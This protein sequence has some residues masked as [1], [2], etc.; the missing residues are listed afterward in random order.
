MADEHVRSSQAVASSIALRCESNYAAAINATLKNYSWLIEQSIARLQPRTT[1]VNPTADATADADDAG[2]AAI[3]GGLAIVLRGGAFRGSDEADGS[4]RVLAQIRCAQS[5]ERFLIRP[6]AR[7]G[8]RAHVFLTLY[9]VDV[10]SPARLEALQRP[11]AQHVRAITTLNAG[12]AEQLTSAIAA[13]DALTLYCS[14]RGESYEAVLLTRYDMLFKMSVIRLLGVE[15]GGEEDISDVRGD[16]E[17][18]EEES[19][20]HQLST[21]SSAYSKATKGYSKSARSKAA[22]GNGRASLQID[23]IRF[24]WREV[25][26]AWRFT[27]SPTSA[28]RRAADEKQLAEWAALAQQMALTRDHVFR[29]AWKTL[30]RTA[31]TIHVLGYAFLRCFRSA[32]AFETTRTWS[33]QNEIKRTMAI[34]PSRA[35]A[36]APGVGL[37]GRFRSRSIPLVNGQPSAAWLNAR[38]LEKYPHN[39]WLHR[40]KDHLGKQLRVD[41]TSADWQANGTWMPTLGYLLPDGAFSS[42]PC[43]AACLL[44]PVYDFLP[45]GD[46]VVASGICQR[47]SDFKY[48]PSSRSLCCPSPD[49]C[50]PNSIANCSDPRAQRFSA[51][52]GRW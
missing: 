2:P 17:S 49:Y 51:L 50:C 4:D 37:D 36:R 48:D 42:N 31:D 24:L 16:A 7:R 27:W 20:A 33:T 19:L 39:H 23:G 38:L 25:G 6:L 13:L 29:P 26:S 3:A 35:P 43:G 12:W 41:T 40:L 15:G 34:P 18:D 30:T 9:D 45:R 14:T 11:F 8:I 52:R 10:A 22:R 1:F 5:V 32:V 46:W 28:Q 44:N 47:W 21:A